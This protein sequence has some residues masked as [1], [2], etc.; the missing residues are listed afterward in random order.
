MSKIAKEKKENKIVPEAKQEPKK[1][2][3][4][5]KRTT[6]AVAK[7]NNNQMI[8]PQN[9][10]T[11][12]IKNNLDIDKFERLVN[13]GIEFEKRQAEKMY[14]E[15]LSAFQAACPIIEK[16]KIVYQ[17]D[18]KTVRYKYAP[19]EDIVSQIQGLL[20][21]YGFSYTIE[22]KQDDKT[23][24][25][26]CIVHHIAGHSKI[27]QVTVPIGTSSYMN[28]I[29]H[30]GSAITYSKRYAFCDAFGIMTGLDDDDGNG[31]NHTDKNNN[32]SDTPD[33]QLKIEYKKVMALISKSSLSEADKKLYVKKVNDNPDSIIE[34]RNIYN[35]VQGK[36]YGKKNNP[37]I[38]SDKHVDKE[39]VYAEAKNIL[40]TKD[41]NGKRLFEPAACVGSLKAV[42]EFLDKNDIKSAMEYIELLRE[43]I[44]PQGDK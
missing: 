1:K 29:Q 40:A 10:L 35:E 30:I 28:N 26:V 14:Y 16:K 41:K 39:K 20:K 8:D 17:S 5:K 22:T 36:L 31:I 42:R 9:L 13:M 12:A 34:M 3:S 2:R 4:Y 18:G 7:V 11:L 43:N 15:S 24:T 6:K 38:K 25:G 27:T 21:E 32:K 37:E 23:L 44:K 33:E 19:I